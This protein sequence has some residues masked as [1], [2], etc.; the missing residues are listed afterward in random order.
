MPVAEDAP[1]EPISRVRGVVAAIGLYR[2]RRLRRGRGSL[3][4]APTVERFAH[5][6]R[7]KTLDTEAAVHLGEARGVPQLGREV[8]VAFDPRF[9]ELDVPALRGHRGEREA[10]RVGAEPVDELE[11]V[12]D[13]AL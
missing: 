1:D 13:I 10:Q 11:R 12:D 5:G 8:A 7:I 3:S 6:R 2:P 4:Q 9:A